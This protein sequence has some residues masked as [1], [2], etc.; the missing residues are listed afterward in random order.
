MLDVRVQITKLLPHKKLKRNKKFNQ[1]V[2]KIYGLI[3]PRS[4]TIFY[5]GCTSIPM[6]ERLYQHFVDSGTFT[7]KYKVLKSLLIND[8]YPEVKV[9]YFIDDKYTARIIEKYITNF[10]ATNNYNID[11]CNKVGMGYVTTNVNL[12]K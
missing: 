9:F 10:L 12:I 6:H 2:H 11:L 5:I 7:P 8:I 1:R 4:N 3:D